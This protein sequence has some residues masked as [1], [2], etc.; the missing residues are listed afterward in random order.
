MKTAQNRV[1]VDRLYDIA[2][3]LQTDV[4]EFF[5][6]YAFDTKVNPQILKASYELSQIKDKDVKVV[7]MK[8]INKLAA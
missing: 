1:T 6:S 2:R 5:P 8:L 4:T 3:C 7:L